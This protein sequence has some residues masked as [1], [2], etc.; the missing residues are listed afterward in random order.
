MSN[1]ITVTWEFL[2][3]LPFAE[4]VQSRLF[5]YNHH[6]NSYKIFTFS[7]EIL[8]PEI[9]SGPSFNR[10]TNREFLSLI[11][12]VGGGG[13]GVFESLWNNKSNLAN[14]SMCFVIKREDD[15]CFV[16]HPT[17]CIRTVN[18]H[19]HCMRDCVVHPLSK[20]SE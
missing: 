6:T 18:E 9:D 19:V 13:G 4:F 7:H 11:P 3:I 16:A 5:P 1:P 12:G 14:N 10:S 15:R 2:S 20:M 17:H 8:V